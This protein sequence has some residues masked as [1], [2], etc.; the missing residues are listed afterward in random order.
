MSLPA[1]SAS[2]WISLFQTVTVPARRHRYSLPESECQSGNGSPS[3]CEIILPTTAITENHRR[4]TSISI[5]I[6]AKGTPTRG[7]ANGPRK[8]RIGCHKKT[9]TIPKGRPIRPSHRARRIWFLLSLRIWRAFPFRSCD[10]LTMPKGPQG[11]KRPADVIGNDGNSAGARHHL[12]R[13]RSFAM[14]PS[15]GMQAPH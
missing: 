4:F 12:R 14:K 9:R 2:R 15:P 1:K 6:C 10:H 11:D 7:Y 3:S 5:A 8:S 13:N